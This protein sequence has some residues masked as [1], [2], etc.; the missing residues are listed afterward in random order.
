[1]L[2]AVSLNSSEVIDA[3][4]PEIVARPRKSIWRAKDLPESLAV[5]LTANPTPENR[6]NNTDNDNTEL[7][8]RHRYYCG[9]MAF[10][11]N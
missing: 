1:M 5:P 4:G 8:L 10:R 7:L 6:N 9:V 3:F 11:N 2:F